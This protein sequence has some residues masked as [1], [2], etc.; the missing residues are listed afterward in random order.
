MIRN[1]AIMFLI[2][3]IASMGCYKPKHI[4]PVDYT[5]LE[6]IMPEN[7]GGI[8][9]I[10]L[11]G[12]Q[13]DNRGFYMSY[14]TAEYSQG[15][16]MLSLSIVD[17]GSDKNALGQLT[18]W[19]SQDINRED[20]KVIERTGKMHKSKY[21]ERVDK[22]GQNGELMMAYQDRF[23]IAL[24]SAG[25]SSEVMHQAVDALDLKALKKVK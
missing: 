11:T 1:V 16:S 12:E 23:V 18:P 8:P 21:F 2:L 3:G 7:I 13:N 22:L 25:F 14:A 15:T 20:D 19:Y 24:K 5:K 10:S 9:Q 6:K 17:I 4:R